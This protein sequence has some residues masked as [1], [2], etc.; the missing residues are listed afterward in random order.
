M[1]LN[2]VLIRI[3]PRPTVGR[4]SVNVPWTTQRPPL[5]QSESQHNGF[6]LLC[7]DKFVTT[8]HFKTVVLWL[9]LGERWPLCT[10]VLISAKSYPLSGLQWWGAPNWSCRQAS[11]GFVVMTSSWQ[12]DADQTISHGFSSV[13]TMRGTALTATAPSTVSNAIIILSVYSCF[14][15]KNVLDKNPIR[16]CLMLCQNSR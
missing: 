5:P 7:C 1:K 2:L 14:G 13:E 4:V 10:T 15:Y 3:W 16:Y 12:S 6:K 9:G 11:T 8:Q